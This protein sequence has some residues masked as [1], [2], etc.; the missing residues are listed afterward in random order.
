MENFHQSITEAQKSTSIYVCNIPSSVAE[1]DVN[2]AF[3]VFGTI[4]SL[5]VFTKKSGPLTEHPMASIITFNNLN[6]CFKAIDQNPPIAFIDSTSNTL[7]SVQVSLYDEN[8]TLYLINLPFK[9]TEQ[10]IQEEIEA[11]AEIPVERFVLGKRFDGKS[12]GFGWATYSTHTQALTALTALH[13]YPISDRFNLSVSFARRR[14]VDQ[15]IIEKIRTLY[16]KNIPLNTSSSTLKDHFED[17]ITKELSKQNQQRPPTIVEA[18]II[19]HD[20]QTQQQMN[21]AFVHFASK[22]MATIGYDILQGY[23][24]EE[25]TLYVEWAEPREERQANERDR[26]GQLNKQNEQRN[27]SLTFTPTPSA[28]PQM[29]LDGGGRRMQVNTRNGEVFSIGQFVIKPASSGEPSNFNRNA[30]VFKPKFGQISLIPPKKQAPL[31]TTPAHAP[32]SQYAQPRTTLID[33]RRQQSLSTQP[34]IFDLST[35]HAIPAQHTQG[36]SHR[37]ISSSDA[38]HSSRSSSTQQRHQ[39]PSF[40]PDSPMEALFEDQLPYL[41]QSSPDSFTSSF[42]SPSLSS[43]F[44][45]GSS[46][47]AEMSNTFDI[48]PSSHRVRASPLHS[49]I[50]SITRSLPSR[51]ISSPSQ[52]RF[53]TPPSALSDVLSMSDMFLA[54]VEP[55]DTFDMPSFSALPSLSSQTHNLT[56]SSLHDGGSSLH[57]TTSSGRSTIVTTT[58]QSSVSEREYSPAST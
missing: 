34:L 53:A 20:H 33:P 15:R 16:V 44:T 31:K 43:S 56:Q 32:L 25:G 41:I 4:I 23:Q 46:L 55:I 40:S 18:V 12:K 39:I 11:I 52:N 38:L 3:S 5:S 6:E 36:N 24:M 30:A 58:R 10:Q 22:D 42:M 21:H 35:L 9:M 13:D 50:H 29:P 26:Q 48:T 51:A 7:V 45:F 28:Q 49:N 47:V 57:S 14:G 8:N 2:T 54:P 27:Q 1:E 37:N 17:L 19:P